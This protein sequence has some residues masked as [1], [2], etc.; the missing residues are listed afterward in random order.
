MCA[1]FDSQ[2]VLLLLLTV[3]SLGCGRFAGPPVGEISANSASEK[4]SAGKTPTTVAAILT[5]DLP[6]H[7]YLANP[8]FAKELQINPA[9]QKALDHLVDNF[10]REWLALQEAE[11]RLSREKQANDT[12]HSTTTLE[13]RKAI[14][15]QS[16]ESALRLLTPAQAQRFH[17]LLFQFRGVEILLEP[18]VRST[19][20]LSPEEIGAVQETR[21]W[22]AENG[23]RIKQ[24]LQGKSRGNREL[25]RRFILL[26]QEGWTR[27]EAHLSPRTRDEL[28]L[29]RGAPAG[30]EE[31]E[32]NLQIQPSFRRGKTMVKAKAL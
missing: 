20:A 29:W 21:V 4:K 32:L 19:L 7:A 9:Q 17:E 28:A 6:A 10:F 23:D 11:E 27:L 30:F 26:R 1:K 13:A 3:I 31:Q 18:T 5:R 12:A 24:E 2:A 15:H 14:V 22:V 8:D 25:T 16:G